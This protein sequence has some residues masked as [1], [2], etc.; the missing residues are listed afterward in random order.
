MANYSITQ[1]SRALKKLS[2]TGL[3]ED[4]DISQITYSK[5]LEF[6]NIA[7]MEKIIILEY[8]E[9]IKNKKVTPFLCGGKGRGGKKNGISIENTTN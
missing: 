5:L 3:T 1:I 4:K 2:D 8:C 6:K 7:P 9:A